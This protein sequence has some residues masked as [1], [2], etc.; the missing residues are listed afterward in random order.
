MLASKWRLCIYL[1]KFF[2]KMPIIRQIEQDL[3]WREGELGLLKILIQQPDLSVKQ[4]QVLL[5]AAWAML[6]A[7]YEGFSKFCLTVF[8]D[9]I[10]RRISSCDSLPRKTKALALESTVKGLKTLATE[11]LIHEIERFVSV[12]LKQIPRFPDVDTESNLWPDKRE[13]LLEQADINADIVR[14]HA[15]RIRT[16]VAR[17]NGIA[18]GELNIISDVDYYL[19]FEQTIYEIMYKMVYLIDERLEKAPYGR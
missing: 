7:H 5:R 11:D 12:S 14:R 13:K 3:D 6:Y 15:R 19:S 9:E 18:H 16:L 4:R 8:Y 17:R 10:C 1:E 2:A